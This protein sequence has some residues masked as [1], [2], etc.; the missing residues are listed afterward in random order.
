MK[1]GVQEGVD[2][3]RGQVNKCVLLTC[4]ILSCYLI[5]VYVFHVKTKLKY[6]VFWE[7]IKQF[8]YIFYVGNVLIRLYR[9]RHVCVDD[10]LRFSTPL[11]CHLSYGK[12][13]RRSRQADMAELCISTKIV[14]FSN[15]N[16]NG[17]GNGSRDKHTHNICVF[18]DNIVSRV[19]FV[20]SCLVLFTKA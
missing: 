3:T 12:R 16:S 6:T 8:A 9:Y 17:N 13:M 18:K 14:N 2:E 10:T 7:I 11:K 1:D 4:Y 19:L 5:W 15:G 20:N